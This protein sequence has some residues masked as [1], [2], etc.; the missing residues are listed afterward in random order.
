MKKPLMKNLKQRQS[1]QSLA[2]YGLILMLVTVFCIAALQL[3]GD[4]MG[5][6]FDYIATEV[7]AVMGG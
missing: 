5:G 4:S 2:E 1:G 3:L 6:M 7:S